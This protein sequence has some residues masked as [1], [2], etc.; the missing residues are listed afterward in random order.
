M[1]GRPSVMLVLVDWWCSLGHV[2]EIYIDVIEPL[3]QIWWIRKSNS[4]RDIYHKEEKRWGLEMY[5]F[6]FYYCFRRK[7]N[8][9]CEADSVIVKRVT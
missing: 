4:G 9:G 3:W 5:L 1:E 8:F 7:R 2:G 6:L